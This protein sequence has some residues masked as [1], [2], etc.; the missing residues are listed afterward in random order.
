[1]EKWDIVFPEGV[2]LLSRAGYY[3]WDRALYEE[4]EPFYKQLLLIYEKD[5]GDN[6]PKMAGALNNLARIYHLQKKYSDAGSLYQRALSLKGQLSDA[7][8]SELLSL[9]ENYADLL[10]TTRQDQ[11]LAVIEARLREVKRSQEHWL[12]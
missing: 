1:M 11:D 10:R 6:H 2:K 8:D 4:A 7:E 9:L 3:L 12:Q 5:L